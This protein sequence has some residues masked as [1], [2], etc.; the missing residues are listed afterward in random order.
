MSWVVKVTGFCLWQDVSRLWRFSLGEGEL[1][2]LKEVPVLVPASF[3][4]LVV[5]GWS[6]GWW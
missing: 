6:V 2:G 4:P 3:W 1:L 5:G